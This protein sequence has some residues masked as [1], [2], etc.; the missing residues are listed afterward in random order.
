M[1]FQDWDAKLEWFKVIENGTKIEFLTEHKSIVIE[2]IALE[3]LGRYRC[4]ATNYY[5]SRS[6]DAILSLSNDQVEMLIFGFVDKR[7]DILFDNEES[8]KKIVLLK[9]KQ[10]DTSPS[11]Q[12]HSIRPHESFDDNLNLPESSGKA[13]K[14]T[15]QINSKNMLIYMNKQRAYNLQDNA[16][17]Q[18]D[19]SLR[20]SKHYHS[21]FIE[22]FKCMTKI[23]LL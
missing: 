2:P 18:I 22:C 1:I 4:I 19:H 6:R 3:D 11:S 17:N 21:S 23:I 13:I 15:K 10:D 7:V 14:F 8:R 9:S 16:N 12:M 5:G 20:K